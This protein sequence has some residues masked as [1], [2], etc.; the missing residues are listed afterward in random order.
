MLSP[1]K[2]PA[3][4]DATY[5]WF[6]FVGDDSVAARDSEIID[7]HSS[8]FGANSSANVDLSQP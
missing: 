4:V 1:S 8:S 6:G 5:S 2:F 3:A 7:P